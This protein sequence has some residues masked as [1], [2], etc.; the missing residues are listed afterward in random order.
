MHLRRLRVGEWLAAAGGVTLLVSLL[1][2]WYGPTFDFLDSGI[3]AWQAF[4]VLDVVLTLIAVLAIALA[5]LQ[6]TRTSPAMPVGAAVLSVVFGALAVILV[7]YRIINQPGPNELVEVRA[8]AWVGL[9]ATLAITA[10]GWASLRDEHVRGLPPGPEP[11][12]RPP[13]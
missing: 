12:L 2:V 5:V 4:V 9:A 10:G 1:I 11:E 3:S 6:A 13:P 8:G 7:A